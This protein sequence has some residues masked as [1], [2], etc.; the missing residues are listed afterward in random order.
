MNSTML[1]T[2]SVTLKYTAGGITY[3]MTKH[4]DVLIG[5]EFNI[6]VTPL[7]FQ[8]CSD[9]SH[10]T[11]ACPFWIPLHTLW[12]WWKGKHSPVQEKRGKISLNLTKSFKSLLSV[13]SFL[14]PNLSWWFYH[15]CQWSPWR[16]WQWFRTTWTK[17]SAGC[18]TWRKS[19][20]KTKKNEAVERKHRS[21]LLVYTACALMS[22]PCVTQVGVIVHS[23]STAVPETQNKT[24]WSVERR[25]L[26]VITKR[27]PLPGSHSIPRQYEG[28]FLFG[29]AVESLQP[30]V[31]AAR[32]RPRL[33]GSHTATGPV[34][35]VADF[36]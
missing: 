17:S 29:Q 5:R 24:P 15:Q 18:Q 13:S 22:L 7:S 19:C 32:F 35:P 1:C 8:R 14:P 27:H 25:T 28:I 23:G 31:K 6:R 33:T 4:K 3:K 11:T 36:L 26:Y 34:K 30:R 20:N 9:H 10:L 21:D 16:G 12:R 2:F